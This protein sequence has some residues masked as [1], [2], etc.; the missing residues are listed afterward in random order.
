MSRFLILCCYKEL[1]QYDAVFNYHLYEKSHLVRYALEKEAL[2]MDSSADGEIVAYADDRKCK[3]M[4]TNLIELTTKNTISSH[5]INIS[6][7]QN[8]NISISLYFQTNDHSIFSSN[9]VCSVTPISIF[10]LLHY[11]L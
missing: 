9:S 3:E 11:F 10:P 1:S 5:N 4:E 7:R 2:S 8:L 6:I